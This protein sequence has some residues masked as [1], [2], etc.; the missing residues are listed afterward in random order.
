M[1]GV[2]HDPDTKAGDVFGKKLWAEVD[3]DQNYSWKSYEEFLTKGNTCERDASGFHKAVRGLPVGHAN[4]FGEGR[5]VLMNLSP[6][7][8]NAFRA[9]GPKPAFKR[10]VFMKPVFDAGVRPRVTIVE[11]EAAHEDGGHLLGEACRGQ[12][13]AADGR[14]RVRQSRNSRKLT[15]RG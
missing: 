4:K 13:A 9:A 8:Y 5:A 2:A 7:W 15:R 11:A 12:T 3:Q 10:E 6:Q 14:I 1:F